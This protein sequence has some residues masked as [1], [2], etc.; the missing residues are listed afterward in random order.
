M[1]GKS[2]AKQMEPVHIEIQKRL[3]DI[4]EQ[5]T[6]KFNE[7]NEK[8]TEKKPPPNINKRNN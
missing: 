5:F 8:L 4:I 1:V 7:L 3:D 2:I 6:A